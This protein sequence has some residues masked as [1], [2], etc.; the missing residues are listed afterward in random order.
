MA[1]K[2]GAGESK[3]TVNEMLQIA[4]SIASAR[5]AMFGQLNGG[6]TLY[7]G[8]RDIYKE[9]GYDKEVTPEMLL[10]RYRR[11]DIAKRVVDAPADETWRIAPVVMDG[12]NEADG[13]LDTEFAKDWRKLAEG[14]SMTDEG[15]TV[16]GL[17]HYLRRIDQ[18]SGIGRF[19]VLLLGFKDGQKLSKPVK[20]PGSRTAKGPDGL[21]YCAVYGEPHVKIAS[22]NQDVKSPRYGMPETYEI[23]TWMDDASKL[24]EIVHWTRCIHV[25]DNLASDDI[26]GLPRMLPVWN[27]L[28]DLEKTMAASGEAAWQLV[29]RGLVFSTRDG[30]KLPDD[31][32]E[33]ENEITDF[34]HGLKRTL[35]LE[36]MDTTPLLGQVVDPQGLVRIIVALIS[37]STGIPQRILLGSERG[38]L[39]S[40]LDEKNWM[41]VIQTRQQSQIAPMLLRPLINRLIWAGVLPP[42]Q[43]GEYFIKWPDLLDT[44]RIMNA[45]AGKKAGEALNLI[46]A[47]VEPEVFASVYMPDLPVGSVT[48]RPMPVLPITEPVTEPI[49]EPDTP[50]AVKDEENPPSPPQSEPDQQGRQVGRQVQE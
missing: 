14:G 24:T 8:K 50:A 4:S 32:T 19:G 3:F 41:R 21:L 46:G 18:L 9:A 6:M 12:P 23:T 10:D 17:L 30:Y 1:G 33:V 48:K 49:T 5:M 26:Y 28:I 45:E 40:S 36:G 7:D 27:R 29:N 38:E 42:P 35:Q 34:V 13:S 39:A 22:F 15:D 44:D 25:A 16:I 20:S 43:G 31:K 2:N 47:E 11:G 37:A